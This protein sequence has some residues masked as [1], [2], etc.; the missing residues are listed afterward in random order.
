M[1]LANHPNDCLKCIRNKNCELQA[2]AASYGIVSS[3][4][5]NEAEEKPPVIASDTI[6]HDTKK[7]I[8]CGRCVEACQEVQTIKAINTAF[9]SHEFDICTAYNQPLKD[10]SCVFC[11]YC[12]SVCPV[13]SIYE[14][15][16][17][18]EV[19]AA[20][21]GENTKAIA[22]FSQ[23]LLPALEKELAIAPGSVTFG[24]LS[25]ALKLMGFDKV[26]DSEIAANTVSAKIINEIDMRKK[27]NEQTLPIISGCS[28]GVNRFINIFY[29]ELKDHLCGI[30][31][32]RKQFVMFKKDFAKNAGVN[33]QDVTSVS[34]VSCLAQKYTEDLDK[35]DFALTVR[36]LAGMI[37]R[38]GIMIETIAEYQFD[39]LSCGLPKQD[40]SGKKITVSGYGQARKLIEAIQK[41]GCNA[42]WLEILSCPKES[43]S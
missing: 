2:L 27:S 30:K 24:K 23:A 31:T 7:C 18:A 5:E 13:G 17:S 41:D 35:T 40:F 19:Q 10:V 4:F 22:Q 33:P 25:A 26:Y 34:F 42:D 16:Q 9:R 39:S 37:K 11:G 43:C 6:V 15:D 38:S 28:E 3:S 14:H 29:P 8:K 20:I 36:E 12:A 1:I 32:T 21:R